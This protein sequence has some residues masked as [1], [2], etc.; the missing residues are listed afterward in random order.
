MIRVCLEISFDGLVDKRDVRAL[1]KSLMISALFIEMDSAR[2]IAFSETTIA[3]VK[4]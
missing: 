2:I 1:G 4:S 3:V